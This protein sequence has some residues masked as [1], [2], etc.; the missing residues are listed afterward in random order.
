MSPNT[1][2]CILNSPQE[3]IVY[4]HFS[5]WSKNGVT[6]KKE[7]N[8]GEH[9]GVSLFSGVYILPISLLIKDHILPPFSGFSLFFNILTGVILNQFLIFYNL[10]LPTQIMYNQRSGFCSDL[11]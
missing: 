8:D 10:W 9:S 4:D 1:G 2:E 5:Q 3:V 11:I 6:K 7:T